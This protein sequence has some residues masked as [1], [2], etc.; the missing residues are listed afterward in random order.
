MKFEN[1]NEELNEY[2]A[3]SPFI[4]KNKTCV[5][6]GIKLS[7]ENRTKEHVIGRKFIPKGQLNKNWNL[8]VYACTSCN[9]EK[10]ELE[11][12]ISA[13]SMQPNS[14][15]QYAD[16]S[17]ILRTES[18]RKGKSISKLTGQAVN[19]S[20]NKLH[21]KVKSDNYKDAMIIFDG[22]PQVETNRL[23]LLAKFHMMAIFYLT[24]YD[25]IKL[26]GS[27]WRGS[28]MPV[29]DTCNGDWGNVVNIDFM[30]K[31]KTWE[32]R[33]LISSDGLYFK[34]VMRKNP[35]YDNWSWALEW[36]KNYRLIGFFGDVAPVEEICKKFRKIE[37]IKVGRNKYGDVSYHKEVKLNMS[38]DVLFKYQ[39][40]ETTN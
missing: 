28:F 29:L 22:P 31:V 38:D 39:I 15:G 18:L 20:K 30:R 14:Y 12:D 25:S 36:N 6:C 8:I 35:D 5:Y 40:K 7:D 11:N 34:A 37:K 10:S 21:M 19:K 17:E 32:P 4:L 13:I 2:N 23:Y 24:T 26:T 16:S 27:F 9:N 33:F 1:L 3:D